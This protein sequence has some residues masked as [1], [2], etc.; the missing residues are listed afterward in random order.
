MQ[1]PPPPLPTW[2]LLL[3]MD[4]GVYPLF[5]TWLLLLAIDTDCPSA[6]CPACMFSSRDILG[7]TVQGGAPVVSGFTARKGAHCCH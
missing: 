1:D 3:A 5:D 7:Q 2:L 6:Q 4:T